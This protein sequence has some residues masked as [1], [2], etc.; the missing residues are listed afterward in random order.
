VIEPVDLGICAGLE[1]GAGRSRTAVVLPGAILGGVP[2][3]YYAALTLFEDGW[4]I[5]QVWDQWDRKTDRLAWVTERADAAARHAG[6][7]ELVVA[8]SISTLAAGWAADRDLRGIWLTPL[9]VDEVVVEGLRR[10]SASLLVG[11][12]EDE[13]WDGALAR[14]LSDDV[15]ELAGADHALARVGDLPPLIDAVRRFAG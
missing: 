3:T 1:W 7:A 13:L 8:K 9:L 12:T 2:S 10:G 5:V 14:E 11:G 6:T 15:L 4:R